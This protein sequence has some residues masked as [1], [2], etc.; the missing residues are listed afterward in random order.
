MT[1]KQLIDA[2][3]AEVPN[4]FS[5]DL[6]TG[7]VNTLAGQIQTRVW[8]RPAMEAS[9][10][11]YENDHA[12]ELLPVPPAFLSIWTLWLRA[13]I[14]FANGEYQKYA[15]SQAFYNAAFGEYMRWFA[16]TYEPAQH[17]Y[18]ELTE[19]GAV[20]AENGDGKINLYALPRGAFLLSVFCQITTPFKAGAILTLGAGDNENALMPQGEIKAE[21]ADRYVRNA[22]MTGGAAG[23]NIIAA[24]ANGGGGGGE[25]VFFGKILL[26]R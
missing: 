2:V 5:N 12:R 9:S 11:T 10:Y 26:P 7:W 1:L 15:N 14:D 18:D 16:E 4:A 17:L 6:K 24:L 23:T 25:A 13:M 21:A 3:D 20:T 22:E 19:L 8:L